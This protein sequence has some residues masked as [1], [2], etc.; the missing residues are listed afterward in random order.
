MPLLRELLV[1]VGYD[2]VS[3]GSRLAR[4][5]HAKTVKLAVDRVDDRRCK[6]ITA[7]RTFGTAGCKGSEKDVRE[8]IIE[9]W[10]KAVQGEYEGESSVQDDT[11]VA[12]GSPWI[13]GWLARDVDGTNDP[14]EE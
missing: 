9:G 7:R 2:A 8:D 6:C 13:N 3:S 12:T 1:Y 11:V 4:L 5:T 14:I 10:L